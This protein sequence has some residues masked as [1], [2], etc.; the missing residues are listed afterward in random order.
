MSESITGSEKGTMRELTRM[1]K[2]RR[3]RMVTRVSQ[4][5]YR[6]L[7]L[8]DAEIRVKG[9]SG[10]YYNIPSSFSQLTPEVA[11]REAFDRAEAW[12][13]ELDARLDAADLED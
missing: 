2:T 13:Q 9:D 4:E 7:I 5:I 6:T 1:Q 11:A 10:N 3:F 12:V 8:A